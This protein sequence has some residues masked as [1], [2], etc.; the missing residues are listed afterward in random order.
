[1]PVE[2][3][4]DNTSL[5]F[6]DTH[7]FPLLILLVHISKFNVHD[8][9][10]TFLLRLASSIYF[11]L[12]MPSIGIISVEEKKLWRTVLFNKLLQELQVI[13]IT[14]ALVTES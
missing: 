12:L 2:C 9:L 7:I 8:T 1:M 3:H 6:H 5:T 14:A 4:G 11:I 10:I 13:Y